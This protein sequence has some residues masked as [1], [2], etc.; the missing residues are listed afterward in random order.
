[1]I[2]EVPDLNGTREEISPTIIPPNKNPILEAPV[3]SL[4]V[5][6]TIVGDLAT[7]AKTSI[8]EGVKLIHS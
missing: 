5:E 1:M 6:P 4:V 2:A 3:P 8:A 7:I